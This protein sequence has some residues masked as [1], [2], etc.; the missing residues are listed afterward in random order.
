LESGAIIVLA[1]MGAIMKKVKHK[2]IGQF[3]ANF[4]NHMVASVLTVMIVSWMYL[5]GLMGHTSA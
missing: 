3:T 5:S 1:D 2:R 4:P